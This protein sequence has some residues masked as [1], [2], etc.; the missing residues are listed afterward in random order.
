MTTRFLIAAICLAYGPFA[1]AGCLY[2]V[3]LLLRFAGR[4]NLLT[5]LVQR[6]GMPQPVARAET[7]QGL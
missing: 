3:G 4:P 1:V 2:L 6:T 5:A 7:E